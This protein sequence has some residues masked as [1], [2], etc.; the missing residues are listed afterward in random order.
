M[1]YWA[2]HSCLEVPGS[3]LFADV[4]A[5]KRKVDIYA[6]T[7][8]RDKPSDP[9]PEV[10]EEPGECTVCGGEHGIIECRRCDACHGPAMCTFC[11]RFHQCM[12]CNQYLCE[13]CTS[14]HDI[15]SCRLVQRQ[16]KQRTRA[17]DER[18]PPEPAKRIRTCTETFPGNDEHQVQRSARGGNDDDIAKADGHEASQQLTPHVHLDE[19]QLTKPQC[20]GRPPGKHGLE[21]FDSGEPPQW[22]EEL[23]SGG[24]VVPLKK[25]RRTDGPIATTPITTTIYTTTTTTLPPS[26]PSADGPGPGEPPSAP[27]ADEPG[28]G[29]DYHHHNDSLPTSI[30]ATTP[31]STTTISSSSRGSRVSGHSGV[32]LDTEAESKRIEGNV[33]CDLDEGA[34]CWGST[35]ASGTTHTEHRIDGEHSH[36]HSSADCYLG[37]LGHRQLTLQEMPTFATYINN[38]LAR[39]RIVHESR[40]HATKQLRIDDLLAAQKAGKPATNATMFIDLAA[41]EHDCDMDSCDAAAPVG[42]R[43]SGGHIEMDDTANDCTDPD[44]RPLKKARTR[45]D[46]SDIEDSYDALYDEFFSSETFNEIFN[47]FSSADCQATPGGQA[48]SQQEPSGSTMSGTSGPSASNRDRR[49]PCSEPFDLDALGQAPFNCT[50]VAE[51]RAL[52]IKMKA[53]WLRHINSAQLNNHYYPAPTFSDARL[54]RGIHNTHSLHACRNLVFCNACGSWKLH[55][56]VLLARPCRGPCSGT[57]PFSLRRL[58]LGQYPVK[59]ATW[60]DGVCAELIFPVRRLD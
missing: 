20:V 19:E 58:R 39:P 34:G 27:S 41:D 14:R 54:T 42:A 10:V 12:H 22:P 48:Q 18:S 24:A 4:S 35:D 56:A 2:K 32:H 1:K 50:E 23:G 9:E 30:T 43:A 28:P 52:K 31:T 3:D 16:S 40:E 55:K 6:D 60:P 5:K 49:T 51:A 45:L 53:D 17:R 37:G 47:D 46:D 25:S 38:W 11:H 57:A 33:E 7:L 29:V 44:S 59:G 36:G 13:A 8:A 26:D 15:D 21:T